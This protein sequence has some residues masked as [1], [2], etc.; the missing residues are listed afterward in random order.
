MSSSRYRGS[1]RSARAQ[2][3][4]V[5]REFLGSCSP[6]RG[7]SEARDQAPLQ[8]SLGFDGAWLNDVAGVMS[9][10][11]VPRT[12]RRRWRPAGDERRG[13][14]FASDTPQE[15]SAEL[16]RDAQLEFFQRPVTI[17]PP[18]ARPAGAVQTVIVVAP[19]GKPAPR[20]SAPQVA[21]ADRIHVPWDAPSP[22]MFVSLDLDDLAQGE[23]PGH[24]RDGL[25][26]GAA[27]TLVGLA[28]LGV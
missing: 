25:L 8:G 21:P 5:A 4:H 13:G 23:E 17:E 15:A 6:I 7:G 27:I 28:W 2:P 10:E 19:A 18:P 26:I 24:A 1:Q 16:R 9:A 20:P 14:G 22:V 11:S 12:T 3:A